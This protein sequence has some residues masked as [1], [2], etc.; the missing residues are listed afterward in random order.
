MEVAPS[1]KFVIQEFQQALWDVTHNKL[2]EIKSYTSQSKKNSYPNYSDIFNGVIK[3]K[4]GS[5][6]EL[7]T[8]L[9]TADI[10]GTDFKASAVRNSNGTP[11]SFT[12]DVASGQVGVCSAGGG[13]T[14]AGVDAQAVGVT[15]QAGV[16]Q[17]INA[18]TSAQPPATP[19]TFMTNPQ[20]PVPSAT[21]NSTP[22]LIPAPQTTP[23]EI[24]NPQ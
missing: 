3:L 5:S 15:A 4:P 19:C 13:E 23:P 7:T 24:H 6:L 8:P 11:N 22:T 16:Q 9:G 12:V 2:A 14:V 10:R 1:S 17:T 20:V 21:P 18:G